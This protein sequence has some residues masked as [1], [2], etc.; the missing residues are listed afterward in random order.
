MK[1]ATTTITGQTRTLGLIADPVLQARSPALVNTRL[2][3]LGLQAHWALLP[4]QVN[5]AQLPPFMAALRAWQNFDGA[6][7]SMPHKTAAASLVDVLTPE[8][9]LVQAVN[10]IK[11]HPDGRLEG[12]AL[13]GHGMVAGLQQHGHR[14]EALAAQPRPL[15][16]R[17]PKRAVAT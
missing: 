8:A 12:T 16:W 11:R 17:S 10:V 4:M 14:I 9:Q 1:Q 2:A 15:P 7:V 5:T 6:I 3:D 13:D